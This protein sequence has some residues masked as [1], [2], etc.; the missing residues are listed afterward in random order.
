MV[1]NRQDV[2][3]V[4]AITREI[5]Q[6]RDEIAK[7]AANIR[8][9]TYVSPLKDDDAEGGGPREGEQNGWIELQ[10]TL[11][12]I[13]V[14]GG[15]ALKDLKAEIEQHPLRSIAIAIGIGYVVARLFS[16]GRNR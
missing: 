16:R 1:N 13:R 10:Q 8:E 6:I 12:E 9:R 11:E 14:K 7:L 3:D 2:D 5:A 15:Q 4:V